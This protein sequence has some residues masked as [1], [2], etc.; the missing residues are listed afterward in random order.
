LANRPVAHVIHRP[1]SPFRGGRGEG[2]GVVIAGG[3]IGREED[4]PAAGTPVHFQSDH[5]ELVALAAPAPT[6]HDHAAADFEIEPRLH[7]G[8]IGGGL[9]GPFNPEGLADGSVVIGMGFDPSRQGAEALAA[10]PRLGQHLPKLFTWLFRAIIYLPN[11]ALEAT[12]H[13]MS[14]W[15]YAQAGQIEDTDPELWLC[16]CNSELHRPVDAFC[17]SIKRVRSFWAL[18]PHLMEFVATTIHAQWE[19]VI[20]CGKT[21]ERPKNEEEFHKIIN[22]EIRRRVKEKVKAGASFRHAIGYD[23][24]RSVSNIE[25][26][27][28]K[29]PELRAPVRALLESQIILAWTAFETLAED[30]W[31]A[32]TI[33]IWDSN[34]ASKFRRLDD[35]RKTYKALSP[36]SDWINSIL[37]DL[38]LVK[39][40]L[41]RH[42]IVHKSGIVDQRFLDESAKKSWNDHGEVINQ[43]IRVDGARVK[44]LVNPVVCV[45][46]QLIQATDAWMKESRNQTEAS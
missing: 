15:L 42:L 12:I 5:V 38:C 34:K 31:R 21:V 1:I 28:R 32:A 46:Q 8:E 13:L 35:I 33:G 36:S 41:I 45:A 10:H 14:E 23:L 40:S 2:L 17:S 39:L 19:V 27:V 11:P 4:E 43:P 3:G 6:D 18:A 24:Q 25:A 37:N 20:D 26:W 16:L 9:F 30:L 44:E 22:E 7:G 29:N